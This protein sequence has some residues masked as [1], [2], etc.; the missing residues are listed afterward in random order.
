MAQCFKENQQDCYAAVKYCKTIRKSCYMIK[1]L[2]D[3]KLTFWQARSNAYYNKFKKVIAKNI[4][5]EVIL[6]SFLFVILLIEI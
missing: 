4:L 6:L 3:C 1:S 2:D 5:L